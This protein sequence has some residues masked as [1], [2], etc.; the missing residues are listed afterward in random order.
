MFCQSHLL[1]FTI[2]IIFRKEYKLWSFS[3]CS[4]LQLPVTSSLFCQNILIILFLSTPTSH[5][6]LYVSS[7]LLE[8][9]IEYMC[10]VEGSL[11]GGLLNSTYKCFTLFYCNTKFYKFHAGWIIMYQDINFSK[12][13]KSRFSQ[14][15][16][17]LLN[18][19]ETIK[20]WYRSG[21]KQGSIPWICGQFSVRSHVI[22]R[23][24][25][26]FNVIK[27]RS[28]SCWSFR[29]WHGNIWMLKCVIV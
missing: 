3:K 20:R 16:F 17:F 6:P 14:L 11:R 2:L 9:L 7:G 10:F 13:L 12:R 21:G 19:L 5:L 15:P 1:D 25:R 4:F 29:W 27:T 8:I 26:F 22:L 28:G 23:E 18:C 24:E